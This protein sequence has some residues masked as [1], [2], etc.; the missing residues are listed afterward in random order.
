MVLNEVTSESKIRGDFSVI[1][2]MGHVSREIRVEF[3]LALHM[4]PQVKK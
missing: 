3:P 4:Y 2:G 1:C